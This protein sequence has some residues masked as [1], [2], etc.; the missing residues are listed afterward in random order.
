MS[1]TDRQTDGQTD[2]A[3]FIGPAGRHGGSNKVSLIRQLVT[4]IIYTLQNKVNSNVNNIGGHRMPNYR[5]DIPIHLKHSKKK[6]LLH[7]PC[8][9]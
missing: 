4:E 6:K 8:E 9:G 3:G 1:Q 7:K 2:G 5:I